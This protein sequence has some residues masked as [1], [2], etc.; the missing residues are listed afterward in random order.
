MDMTENTVWSVMAGGL[1]SLALLAAADA[2]ITRSLGAVRNVLLVSFIGSV[3]VLMSGLPEQLFP[4]IPERLLMVLKTSL[5]P[6]AGALGLRFLGI[7]IGGAREDRL[8][9]G[10]TVWGCYLM[11]LA[12]ATLALLTVMAPTTEF[13][14]LLL[15][16]AA[17]NGVTVALILLVSVRATLMGDPLALW[18]VVASVLLAGT[19]TGL[20]L[21]TLQVPLS[22]VWWLLTASA[23]LLFVLIVMVLIIVR[24]RANR[25]LARLARLDSGSDPVTGLPTGARLLSDVEHAFWRAGRLRGQCVVVCVYLSNLYEL[26]D[27][28][29]RTTDNQILA[30]TAARIRRA[31][32]FRCVVGVYHPRC[33][34]IVFTLDRKRSFDDAA[35]ARIRNLVTQPLQVV[36]NREQ[37]Q[38]FQP[39]VGLSALPV[40]P[41]RVQPLDVL[42]E[43]EHQAM[44]EVRR[45]GPPHIGPD[46]VPDDHLDTTW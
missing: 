22:V 17:V 21:H 6:L 10:V 5:G 25:E 42:N 19:M 45:N 23:A 4:D 43:A 40:L 20:Y 8:L 12:A 28:I 24:N 1:L 11:L 15:M 9:Y 33:F 34:I 16:S 31:A 44:E 3:C 32:G 36:G 2:L 46:T 41:D 37:R 26:G 13:R 35:L 29:G 27:S 18:L 14:E 30:A 38:Q 7:W 39:V